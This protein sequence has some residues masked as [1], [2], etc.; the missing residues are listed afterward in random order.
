MDRYHQTGL[1]LLTNL[2]AGPPAYRRQAVPTEGGAG[3]EVFSQ[4]GRSIRPPFF[5][6]DFWGSE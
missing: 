5:Y 2:S 4:K 1:H 3:A 6:L